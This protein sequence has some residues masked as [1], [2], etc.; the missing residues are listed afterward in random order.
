MPEILIMMLTGLSLFL[1]L[2]LTPKMIRVVIHD[3]DEFQ[4]EDAFYL[5]FP[6]AWAVFILL[7][8]YAS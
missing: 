7:R 6:L 4:H 3:Y 5:L 2:A 8:M 1:A